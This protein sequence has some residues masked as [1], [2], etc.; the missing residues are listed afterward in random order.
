MTFLCDLHVLVAHW[1][2]NKQQL[3]PRGGTL[4]RTAL[5]CALALSLSTVGCGFGSGPHVRFATATEAD[6]KAS[7]NGPVWYE[8]REGD[9]VP[10]ALLYRGVIEAGAPVRAKAKK[11]FWLVLQ[12]NQPAYFSFDGKTIAMNGS[13]AGIMV[14]R[15][16]GEN[17]VG[18]VVYVGDPADAPPELRK[19]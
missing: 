10:L 3:A 17:F 11:K 7:A 15:E 9:D 18:V 12:P 19:H 8:F 5:A 16:K 2:M 6:L 4:L 1:G 14:A 13:T